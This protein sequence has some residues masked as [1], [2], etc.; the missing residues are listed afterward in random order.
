MFLL[1]RIA[2]RASIAEFLARASDGPYDLRKV[3][4]EKLSDGYRGA[5][6]FTAAV[7]ERSILG[8]SVTCGE[9]LRLM[10]VDPLHRRRGIGSALLADAEQRIAGAYGRIVLGAEPGNYFTPGVLPEVAEFFFRREYEVTA[11]PMNLECLAA[12][13]NLRGVRRAS[14]GDRDRVISWIAE[15]FGRIWAFETS[16]AFEHPIPTL[17]L[18]EER[19][20]LAGFSAW[21][22]NNA[23]LGGYGPA[24][25]TPSLRGRGMGR[26]LLL[27]SLA[28]MRRD[29]FGRALIQW[30]AGYEFYRH[31]CGARVAH[32]FLLLEKRLGA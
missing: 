19:G 27:G 2:Q 11:E 17:V 1:S 5:P 30:A 10:A 28:E 32:R 23:A 24:G 8:A 6:V 13:S 14:A 16:R 15:T 3:I 22:A 25:V 4:A 31:V 18:A 9:Y 21:G 12:E 26:E 20:R 7:S 29:G